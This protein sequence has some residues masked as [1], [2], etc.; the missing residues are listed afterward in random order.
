[1]EILGNAIQIQLRVQ[2]V[3]L[4]LLFIPYA[5]RS[6]DLTTTIALLYE[7]RDSGPPTMDNKYDSVACSQNVEEIKGRPGQR[8]HRMHQ[9][10]PTTAPK[11]RIVLCFVHGPDAAEA[12]DTVVC[13]IAAMKIH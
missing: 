7:I 4:V 5:D 2:T 12:V 1:M 3:N 8:M 13:V 10:C 11:G 6:P 9:F